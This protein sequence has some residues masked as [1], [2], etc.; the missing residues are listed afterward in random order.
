MAA[1]GGAGL[2][3]G[4]PGAP[5][6]A[7]P[8]GRPVRPDLGVTL[9]AVDK[10]LEFR[11]VEALG[12]ILRQD[13]PL[14]ELLIGRFV[15]SAVAVIVLIAVAG[16]AVGANN[17]AFLTCQDFTIAGSDRPANCAPR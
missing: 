2:Q 14:G 15:A 1:V 6:A 9:G 16:Y 5:A 11:L 13:R 7:A 3:P 4:L 17:D 10:G 12:Q 8:G